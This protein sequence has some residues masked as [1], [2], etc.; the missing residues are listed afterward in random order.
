MLHRILLAVLL[1]AGLV[2][3]ACGGRDYTKPPQ[4]V[5]PE[6]E[7]TTTSAFEPYADTLTVEGLVQYDPSFLR[8]DAK[9]SGTLTI[10]DDR[11]TWQNHDQ[12]KRSF[13]IQTDVVES[14]T[15]R[16]ATTTGRK[17]CL[18]LVLSTVTDL[19]YRFRD[20]DWT[21]G[22]NRRILE[23]RDFLRDEYPEILFN[24]RSVDEID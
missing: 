11:I 8:K 14:I 23:V 21:A 22:E 10:A 6:P 12:R 18:E 15:L 1:V 19:R 17:S 9:G 13:S 5:P 16:C 7:R 2:F 20:P 24:E 4:T 3:G